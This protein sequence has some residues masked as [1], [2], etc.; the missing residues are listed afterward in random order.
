MW[1]EGQGVWRG[2]ARGV[3][4]R[5]K[6]C[7]GEGQ[8]VWREEQDGCGMHTRREVL[9]IVP[10]CVQTPRSERELLKQRHCLSDCRLT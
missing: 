10:L 3:V 7:G 6:G 8:G 2:G 9:V 4:G 1:W 5:G